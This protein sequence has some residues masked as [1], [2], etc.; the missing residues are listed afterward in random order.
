[1]ARREWV[2]CWRVPGPCDHVGQEEDASTKD[3]FVLAWVGPPDPTPV[4][5]RFG[6]VTACCVTRDIYWAFQQEQCLV[7]SPAGPCAWPT[8][9]DQEGWFGGSS[10]G[11][12][13]ALPVDRVSP[14][15]TAGPG[16]AGGGWVTV[17]SIH[18]PG[19]HPRGW[20][21]ALPSRSRNWC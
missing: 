11:C 2:A 6:L 7:Q 12:G 16:V 18:S 14:E 5:V 17:G 19:V 4:R 8:Q 20:C 3:L 21:P 13:A 1:M 10:R 9:W 15:G